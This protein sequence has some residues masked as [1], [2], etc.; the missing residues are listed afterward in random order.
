MA[1]LEARR[2]A[3]RAVTYAHQTAH[4]QTDGFEHAPHF[5]IAAFV[6]GHVIP[7]IAAL[8]APVDEAVELGRTVFEH[9]T[10]EQLLLLLVREF[11]ED[12][13]RV[14]ALQRIARMHH[15]VGQVAVVG[16]DQQATGIEVEATDGDPAT[17]LE[18]RQLVEHAGTAFRIVARDDLALRL[19]ID[20]HTR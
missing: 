13:H 9:D 20:E 2:Q 6:Q 11:A 8:A 15:A 10:V 19:M 17:G 4:G 5:T 7:V 3:D 1:A 18:A 16:D 14:L 12:T